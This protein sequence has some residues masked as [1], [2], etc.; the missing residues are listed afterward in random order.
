M[1]ESAV[2][3]V[4]S[5][6]AHLALPYHGD[7]EYL[8]GAVPF[9][10]K[11]VASDEAV[12][13]AVPTRQL[14]LLRAELG[15]T[16]DDVTLLDMTEVGVNPG[17]IIPT[18][19]LAFA[20]R[21]RDRHVRI[22]SEPMW[23]ARRP[24]EYLACVRHD[25]L[26]NAAFAGRYATVL[27]PFE[28]SALPSNTAAHVARTHPTMLSGAG[29]KPSSVF[30]PDMAVADTNIPLLPPDPG[31][32]HLV[33]TPDMIQL[34]ELVGAFA[35]NNGLGVERTQDLVLALTELASNSIEHAHSD[36]TV[37]FG[38]IGDRLV[39]QVRDSGHI[40]DPMAG[41]R[42]APPNQPRGRGLLLVNQ[43]ADLVRIHSTR[44]GTTVEIQFA[45][46]HA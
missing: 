36:A 24:D 2:N 11:G 1:T 8:S 14:A 27:C 26:V 9:I 21:R 31:H 39:C 34:R 10:M 33:D 38:R 4:P 7:A 23:P 42:P 3:S 16:A 18:V 45:L 6:F 19:L 17:R 30:A 28:V 20:D 32:S 41:Q 22:L 12:L 5:S 44:A 43:L 46:P 35:L 40:T 37:V 15:R 25:A 13:V 29:T